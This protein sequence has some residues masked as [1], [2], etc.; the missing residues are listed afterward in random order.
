MTCVIYPFGKILLDGNDLKIFQLKWLREQMGLVSQEP[1]LFATTIAGNI[2]YGKE[3]ASMEQIIEAAKASN[4]HSFIQ[5]L[6][7]G[8]KTQVGICSTQCPLNTSNL[9]LRGE[10]IFLE[11][12]NRESPVLR[13]PRILL[14]DEALDAESEQVVQQAV[15]SIMSN[16]TTIIVAHRLSTIRDVDTIVVLKTG[17]VV[18]SGNHLELMSDKKGEYATLVSLQVTSNNN[19]PS[20]NISDSRSSLLSETFNSQIHD[21]QK[22]NSIGTKERFK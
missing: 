19:D 16:Q 22:I 1:A 17:L 20:Q 6:P 15:V 2:L 12:R 3:D 14:L 13:N 11:D 8:Y 9:L 5:S 4:A 7:D 21:T 10:L 18:E